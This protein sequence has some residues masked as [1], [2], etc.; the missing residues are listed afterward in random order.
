MVIQNTSHT[1]L[2]RIVHPRFF[3]LPKELAGLESPRDILT[4]HK[5]GRT[6]FLVTIN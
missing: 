5:I 1:Q 2:R 3:V 6:C 4:N